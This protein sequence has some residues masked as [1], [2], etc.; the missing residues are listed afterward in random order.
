[1]SDFDRLYH[2]LAQARQQAELQAT[3]SSNIRTTNEW[4]A[5]ASVANDMLRQLV[6]FKKLDVALDTLR[7]WRDTYPAYSVFAVT[8][9]ATLGLYEGR[10]EQVWVTEEQAKA[11]EPEAVLPNKLVRGD[12]FSYADRPDIIYTALMNP[13]LVHMAGSEVLQLDVRRGE[14]DMPISIPAS[15][16]VVIW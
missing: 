14:R 9:D 12:Q 15:R 13:Q 4:L 5:R 6:S 11:D 3:A 8:A 10:Y 16:R 2:A 1:M 7:D